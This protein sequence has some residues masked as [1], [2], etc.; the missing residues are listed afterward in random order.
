[1]SKKGAILFIALSII[2]G[3]PYLL[4]KLALEDLNPAFIVFARSAP[5]AI[6]L[7][8]Y[9]AIRG[10]L[11]SNLKFY[12]TAIGFAFVEMIFPW[13]FINLAEQ[14]ISSSLAGLLLATVP[15]FGVLIARFRGD[16]NAFHQR[17][18]VGM[19][20]GTL[21]VVILVGLD[22]ITHGIS[23]LAVVIVLLAAF[24]YA[25]GPVI[26]N[27]TLGESDSPTVIGMSLLIVSLVYT[28]FLPF[29]AP[30]EVPSTTSIAAVVTLSIV[31]TV[32]AFLLFF[33]L[34]DE[35]GPVRVTLITYLNP[36]VAL[37]LG[38]VFLSEPITIGLAIGFPMVIIGSWFASSVNQ[39]YES[40]NA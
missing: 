33:A 10:K 16:R 28:P 3:I 37:I 40:V 13:W 26:V 7:L 20:I 22:S 36:A 39:K 27:K 35:I 30:T 34:I 32:I 11:R 25:L 29:I 8:V 6:L 15:I 23:I 31:C 4:I 12:K 1:V 21:G 5:A 9:S 24:G 17:R 18:I 38:V 19:L 2:W 14:D